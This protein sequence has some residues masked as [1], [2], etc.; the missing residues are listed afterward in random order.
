MAVLTSHRHACAPAITV[1]TVQRSAGYLDVNH[2][3][4]DLGLVFS[5]S[6][7]NFCHYP[8]QWQS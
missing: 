6:V 1:A 8:R 3:F 2:F 4:D 7:I 5:L